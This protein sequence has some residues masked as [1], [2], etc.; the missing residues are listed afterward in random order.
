MFFLITVMTYVPFLYSFNLSSRKTKS[1]FFLV[2]DIWLLNNFFAHCDLATG[3]NMKGREWKR[4][5]ENQKKKKKRNK[6]GEKRKIKKDKDIHYE[7]RKMR[8]DFS[9]LE[10]VS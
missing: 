4:K 6:R 8:A 3:W 10:N 2:A 5:K 7:G 1:S 9:L